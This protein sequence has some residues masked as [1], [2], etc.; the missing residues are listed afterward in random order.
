MR[1]TLASLA[2]LAM[3]AAATTAL[4]GES[5]GKVKMIDPA[6][7]TLVLEDGTMYQ[8]SDLAAV[9]GLR[10]GQTVTVSYE[11]KDGRHQTKKVTLT[12]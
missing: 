11:T 1:K 12:K 5:R 7:K 9:E 6:T 10:P 4:A 2:A 8:V 3:I